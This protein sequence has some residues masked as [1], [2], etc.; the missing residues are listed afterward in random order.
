MIKK[1]SPGI[2]IFQS[3]DHTLS[4]LHAPHDSNL[5]VLNRSRKSLSIEKD[6][7]RLSAPAAIISRIFSTVQNDCTNVDNVYT[8]T[9]V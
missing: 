7:V 8:G 9:V 6:T 5:I 1:K 4:N 3:D 2:P